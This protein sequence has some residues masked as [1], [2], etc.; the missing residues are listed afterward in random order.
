MDFRILRKK[1][2]RQIHGIKNH[3]IGINICAE[4]KNSNRLRNFVCEERENLKLYTI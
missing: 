1:T 3:K 4:I 2:P